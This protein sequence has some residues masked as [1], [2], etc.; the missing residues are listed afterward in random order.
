MSDNK[1]GGGGQGPPSN[2]RKSI[3]NSGVKIAKNDEQIRMHLQKLAQK[4]K[5][6]IIDLSKN[7]DSS[8]NT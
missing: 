6:N 7:I 2:M 4:Q 5:R 8:N 1:S 3:D